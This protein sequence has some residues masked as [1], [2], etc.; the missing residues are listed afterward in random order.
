MKAITIALDEEDFS[1][2]RYALE[3]LAHRRME[4]SIEVNN[5]DFAGECLAEYTRIQNL[6]DELHDCFRKAQQ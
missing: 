2:I 4:Q 1:F 6:S 5:R 3:D